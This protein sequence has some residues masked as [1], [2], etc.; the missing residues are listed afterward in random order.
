M[1]NKGKVMLKLNINDINKGTKVSLVG[2]GISFSLEHESIIIDIDGLTGTVEA[3]LN[4]T[5]FVR[6]LVVMDE[7]ARQAHHK[8]KKCSMRWTVAESMLEKL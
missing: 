7:S 3:K 1:Y 2:K 8:L 6:Y 5:H 4:N